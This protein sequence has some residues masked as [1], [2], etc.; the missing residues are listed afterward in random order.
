MSRKMP[1][2]LINN[3][4]GSTLVEMIVC[5]ALLGIF[6]ACAA[7]FISTITNLFYEIKGETYSR[8]VSDIVLQKVESELDG[9]KYYDSVGYGSPNPYIIKSDTDTSFNSISLDDKTDTHVTIGCK[10]KKLLVHYDSIAVLPENPGEE[11]YTLAATDWMFDDEVYEGFTIENMYIVPASKLST[12]TSDYG[13]NPAT[14][15]VSAGNYPNN[16]VV[17]LLHINSSKYGDFYTYRFVKMYNV[18]ESYIWNTG[19]NGS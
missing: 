10:N 3:N 4:N 12:A 19:N 18:S 7:T 13:V 5:F 17:V 6:M 11:G 16:I 15:G 14:Y 2:K 9:A 1:H 8:Q